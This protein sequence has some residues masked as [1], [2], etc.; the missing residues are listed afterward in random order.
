MEE[1]DHPA[2][3]VPS[4]F[5]KLWAAASW[6]VG[7]GGSTEPEYLLHFFFSCLFCVDWMSS[8]GDSCIDSYSVLLLVHIVDIMMLPLH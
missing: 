5:E 6:I 8:H 3:T 4:R 2:N 1:V 7:E